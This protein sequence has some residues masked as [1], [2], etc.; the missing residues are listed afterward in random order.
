[1][2]F[3]NFS[4]RRHFD[5]PIKWY[6]KNTNIISFVITKIISFV[7]WNLWRML[8]NFLYQHD[9][10]LNFELWQKQKKPTIWQTTAKN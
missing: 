8:I 7:R 5:I 9:V 2:W 4:N 3:R 1:M 10:K 6:K